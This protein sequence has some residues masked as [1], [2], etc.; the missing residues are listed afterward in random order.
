MSEDGITKEVESVVRAIRDEG[1]VPGYHRE[2][3]VR[4]RREWP[5]LWNALDDLLDAA[6][7]RR[8]QEG[9]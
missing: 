6:A 9:A 2:V 4:H 8:R 7:D 5:T 1:P 3:M